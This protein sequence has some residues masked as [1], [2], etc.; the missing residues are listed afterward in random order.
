MSVSKPSDGATLVPIT[1]DEI[2]AALKKAL[3]EW[4]NEQFVRVGRWTV[5]GFA[6]LIFAGLVYIVVTFASKRL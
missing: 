4:L 6:A 2:E 1:K 5:N 3:H